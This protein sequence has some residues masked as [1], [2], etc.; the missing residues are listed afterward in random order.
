MK[1][2]EFRK[3]VREK[4]LVFDGAMGTELQKYGMKKGACPEEL[5]LVNKEL[6]LRVNKSYV[7]AGSDIIETNTFGGNRLKL[8]PYN[9]EHKVKDVN[10]YAVAIAKEAIG[11]K[12]VLVAGSVG[13]TGELFYPEGN[14]TIDEAY[15]IFYEQMKALY[16]G[17][18]DLFII[19]TITDIEEYKIA[20]RA[21]QEFNIGL[22]AQ[23]TFTEG[24]RTSPVLR[25]KY[26]VLLQKDLM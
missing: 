25:L 1:R 8:K 16:D 4:I 3:A 5:N 24:T 6:I 7:E 18:A 11:N 15:D 2:V 23:M 19:E 17:G 22:V 26:Y 9:L 20:V 21:A 10:K 14:L 12:K 13:P